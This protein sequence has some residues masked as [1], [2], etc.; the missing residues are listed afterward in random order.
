MIDAR[1]IDLVY[2]APMSAV[3]DMLRSCLYAPPGK[4]LIAADYSAIEGRV[5]AWLAQEAW[6]LAAFR[7]NDAGTGPGIYELTAAGILN[8]PVSAITKAERQANGK[9]PE[10]ALGFAGG[11][12]AFDAMAAIYRVDMADAYEPLRETVDP[13]LWAAAER[14]YAKWSKGGLLATDRMSERAWIASDATKRAW[15]AK[16]PAIVQWWA[17]LSDAVW[18]AVVRPGAVTHCGPLSYVVKRGFLWCKLPSGRCLAYGAPQVREV[19]TPWGD[20][21]ATPTALGVDSKTKRWTRFPLTPQILSENPVQA[22][23]RDLMAHGM[24]VAEAAGY[25]T[26]MTVH[27]EAVAEVDEGF[28]SVE[29]YERLLCSPP[30]WARDALPIPLPYVASGYAARRYRKE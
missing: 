3:S 10:L 28:G 30:A 12:A 24:Q 29:D 20:K 2:G 19:K 8:K 27:D 11:V 15:R 25:P 7:A 16:H 17:D 5:T 1:W 26:V 14:A 22:V 13:D 9:V 23:A 18:D 21:Q 4:I 6:K